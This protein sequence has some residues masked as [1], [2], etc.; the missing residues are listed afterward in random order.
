MHAVVTFDHPWSPELDDTLSNE[1]K[2]D[3][4]GQP[5]PTPPP[6]APLEDLIRKSDIRRG[7]VKAGGQADGRPASRRI[8]WVMIWPHQDPGTRVGEEEFLAWS[9]MIVQRV[10]S[11]STLAK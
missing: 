7:W 2:R 3:Q 11:D 6:T 8:R 10:A 5:I 4:Y 1:K 9:R